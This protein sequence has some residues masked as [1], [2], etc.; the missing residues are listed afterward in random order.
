[1]RVPP[2]VVVAGVA[3]LSSAFEF[4]HEFHVLSQVFS[5]CDSLTAVI[6]RY[7]ALEDTPFDTTNTSLLKV[8]LP[9]IGMGYA[10][11]EFFRTRRGPPSGPPPPP[12]GQIAHRSGESM[13]RN[14]PRRRRRRQARHKHAT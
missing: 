1:M 10:I 5:G 11:W 7:V 8:S 3:G 14:P 12:S 9:M 4:H 13:P 6:D 2:Y